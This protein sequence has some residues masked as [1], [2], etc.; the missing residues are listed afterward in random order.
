M[1]NN[2]PECVHISGDK[3]RERR[4]LLG[5]K[6]ARLKRV[7]RQPVAVPVLLTST[8]NGCSSP[9]TAHKIHSSSCK[10]SVP[11]QQPRSRLRSRTASR[12]IV[13]PAAAA[14]YKQTKKDRGDKSYTFSSDI[15]D[16]SV[17]LLRRRREEERRRGERR[18]SSG[19]VDRSLRCVSPRFSGTSV[20]PGESLAVNACQPPSR[21]RSPREWVSEDR[22]SGQVVL[23]QLAAVS[24]QYL[25]HVEARAGC[26]M[27]KQL[28]RLAVQEDPV[29]LCALWDRHTQKLQSQ[30]SNIPPRNKWYQHLIP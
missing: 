12:A 30:I 1:G 20:V 15:A 6:S 11:T 4:T 18:R 16:V 21:S 26:L 5:E 9:F 25:D 19:F 8:L 2:V 3:T 7:S 29:Y 23:G 27:G 10:H 24:S 17:F 28:R 14:R 22:T 13:N